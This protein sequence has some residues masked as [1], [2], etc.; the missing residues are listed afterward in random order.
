MDRRRLGRT[1]LNVSAIGF[2]AFKIG[3]CEQ[4]KY[5]H[6]YELP[7]EQT[8]ARL[9]NGVLDLGINLIDTA[10]A[11]GASEERIGR[12][13]SH[14]RREFVLAT[15]VG[16]TFRDG[17]SSYDF[18]SAAIRQSVR[19]SLQNL[20]TDVIDILLIHSSGEDE[21]ILSET[22]AVE[23]LHDLRAAGLVRAIGFS[24]KT[25]QGAFAALRWADVLMVEYH[26]D[27]ASHEGVL[28]EARSGDVGVLVKKGLASGHL[29]PEPAIR[30]VLSN[31]AVASLVLGSL[32]LAHLR[33]A[34]AIV[35][36]VRV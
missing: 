22:D 28:A 8:V 9:L 7:D 16:E 12:A 15:K 23:T 29:E 33:D 31:P 5:P 11:Y 13:L 24:G 27:D 35:H 34:A 17:R 25:V 10:P 36:R 14:R 3:R 32:D 30:F 6:T 2:G 21:K 19:R 4:I 18:S 1:G 20:Q 26:L